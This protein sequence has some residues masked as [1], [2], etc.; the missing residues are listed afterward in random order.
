MSNIW[1]P[2]AGCD[3]TYE[4][5]KITGWHTHV[6]KMANHPNWHPTITSGT[7]RQSLFNTEFAAWKDDAVKYCAAH[8]RTRRIMSVMPGVVRTIQPPKKVS[9][10]PPVSERK[11]AQSKSGTMMRIAS[12]KGDEF[13]KYIKLNM[14]GIISDE[15]FALLTDKACKELDERGEAYSGEE[16][17]STPRVARTK[18]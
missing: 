18:S 3:F 15:D 6:V 4:N 14:A 1:C 9:E 12:H 8:K 16:Q 10:P 11:P 17:E 2:I 7:E 13:S 5:N